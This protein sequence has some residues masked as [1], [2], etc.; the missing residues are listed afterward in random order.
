MSVA[1]EGLVSEK[2]VAYRL[3][4]CRGPETVTGIMTTRELTRSVAEAAAGAA[5]V[6]RATS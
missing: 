4:V 5:A 2:G 6:A 3:L 1:F